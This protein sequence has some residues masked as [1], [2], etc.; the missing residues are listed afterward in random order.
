MNKL[1]QLI[2][3]A[4][5]LAA[6]QPNPEDILDWNR[7]SFTTAF[8]AWAQDSLDLEATALLIDPPASLVAARQEALRATTVISC[9]TVSARPHPEQ[10]R[11]S[12]RLPTDLSRSDE[13][14]MSLIRQS[15][16]LLDVQ[17]ALTV[18]P[19]GGPWIED[20]SLDQVIAPFLLNTLTAPECHLA[21]C[22]SVRTLIRGGRFQS[23]VLAAD[24]RLQ[25]TDLIVEDTLLRRFPLEAQIAEECVAAGLHGVTLRPLLEGPF[26][27]IGGIEL[28]AFALTAYT[29]TAGLCFEQGDAAIYLGPWSSVTDDDGHTYPRGT[30]IAVCAKTAGV[31]KSAPYAGQFAI[32]EAYD[33][34]DLAEAELFDCSRDVT[35]PVAETKGR[36]PLGRGQTSPT[37]GACADEGCGC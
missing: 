35:R 34:P 36:V 33:R 21:L 9:A 23:V 1:N 18:E 27:T 19:Q 28:R 3:G 15:T 22:E 16:N 31:L 2:Q 8:A 11:A 26:V 25:G 12:H 10:F 7:Q 32:V 37:D 24:E 6:Q 20:D 30:R 4:A 17:Q 5:K 13:Q 14:I 29:G